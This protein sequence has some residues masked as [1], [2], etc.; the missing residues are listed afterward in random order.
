MENFK[1]GDRVKVKNTRATRLGTIVGV[2][3]ED[4]FYAEPNGEKI[5]YAVKGEFQVKL[6]NNPEGSYIPFSNEEIVKIN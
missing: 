3:E 2:F 6:D 1:I 5:R 4:F